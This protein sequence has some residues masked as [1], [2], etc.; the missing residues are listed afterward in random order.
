MSKIEKLYFS[1]PSWSQ[2][3]SI[4]VYAFIRDKLFRKNRYSN[5]AS[6]LVKLIN[7]SNEE[8]I[9][10]WQLARLNEIVNH[11][12]RN[13]VFYRDFYGIEAV[14]F[15]SFEDFRQLP[16]IDKQLV[17]E[18][19]EQFQV[20]L[21]EKVFK[22]HTS[23]TTGSSLQLR[24]SANNTA[25]EREGLNFSRSLVGY[26][27]GDKLASFIGR[28]LMNTNRTTPP[29]WRYNFYDKQLLFSNWHISEKNLPLYIERY[30]KYQPAYVNGYPSFLYLFA[31]FSIRNSLKLHSPKAVFT[32]SETLL[33]HHREVIESAF[34]SKIYDHYGTAEHLVVAHQCEAASYHI[35]EELGY[36]EII[37]GE[38]YGT[39]FHNNA[40]PLIRY[41]IGDL[42]Q[43]RDEK[44]SC[45]LSG[46]VIVNLEG[47]KDDIVVAKSGKKYGRI[48]R[49]FQE[50]KNI[51]EAQ[52]VQESLEVLLINIVPQNL[53]RFSLKEIEAN[54]TAKLGEDFDIRFQIL[55]S[56]PRT[57]NG[58]FRFVISRVTS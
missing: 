21:E 42:A 47:R 18:N 17:R 55:E 50:T 46:R 52:I 29:F 38:V 53:E 14:D 43:L 37:D 2:D 6:D 48:S 1:L 19:W 11:A 7:Q 40:M 5:R 36:L 28:K 24:V 4:S 22:T 13:T 32:G 9:R 26:K 25:V 3:I 16:L 41:R 58:K 44:C 10:K 51:K 45:G 30:N 27:R 35:R 56:I 54:I 57:K 34:N 12:L 20:D 33:P 23:G 15:K 49:I 31:E 8:E 39:T